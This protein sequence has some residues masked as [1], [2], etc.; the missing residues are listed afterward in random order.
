MRYYSHLLLLVFILCTIP[1][2]ASV[3]DAYEAYLKGEGA[4]TLEERHDNFR[5]SLEL[6][7][8]AV[9]DSHSHP[10]LLY[11]LG[12]CYY[13]LHEYPK[14]VLYY[15]RTLE[16]SPRHRDAK[17]NCIIAQQKLGV[18]E[19]VAFSSPIERLFFFH[20]L[21]SIPEKMIACGLFFLG[22]CISF[23]LS[24]WGKRRAFNSISIGCG[25]TALILYCSILFGSFFSPSYG[26]IMRASLLRSDKGEHYSHVQEDPLL[27]GTRVQVKGYTPTDDWLQIATNGGDTGFISTISLELI[28]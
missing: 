5:Q 16:L 11:S 10:D 14:A 17:K 8:S 21:L 4:T 12:N 1:S 22:G 19:M 23:S 9:K 15:Y 24:M 27:P 28:K 25:I 26:I 2:M 13:H 7:I 3:A 18:E 6:Y 20:Y